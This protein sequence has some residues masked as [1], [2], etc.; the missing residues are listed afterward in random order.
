MV[1]LNR[2]LPDE[3]AT[4]YR[5]LTKRRQAGDLT[6]DD[7]RELLDL[8]DEV[9]RLQ[10]ERIEHLADLARLRGKPLGALMEELGIRPS[11]A[12]TDAFE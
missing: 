1:T 4:R 7:H 6:P 2:G 5:E 8:T 12:D 9:E 3:K 11:L 10:A